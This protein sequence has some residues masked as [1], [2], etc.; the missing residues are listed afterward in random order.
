MYRAKGM[1]GSNGVRI[2]FRKK[3]LL[4]I[5]PM[6]CVASMVY[7]YD[8][9]RTEK[10]IVRSEIIKRAEAIT[11]LA[12][13]TGEL[14]ILSGSGEFLKNAVAPLSENPE[15]VS[16]AFF[17]AGMHELIR[18]GRP[19]PGPL[20]LLSAGNPISMTDAKDMFIFYAPIFAVRQ[21]DAIGI[22][23]E[24]SGA[25]PVREHIGW[26]QL[27]F[28]KG[29]MNDAVGKV[30]SRGILLA[31]VFT[32]GISLAVFFLIT[33]TTRPLMVLFQA[34]KKLEK[35]EY[36]EIKHISS[37][38]EIGQLAVAFNRMS[39]A[40]K[41]RESALVASENRLRELFERVEHAIFRLDARGAIIDANSRFRDLFGEAG[42][43]GDVV[44][45]EKEV[46]NC[47]QAAS[48][49]GAVHREKRANGK[50]GELVI[51]LS[52][53]PVIGQGGEIVGYDGYIMDI[54]EKKTMEEGLLRSQK[55]EAV[56]TLAG[57]MAHD[58]NNVLTAILGYSELM[59]EEIKE[60]EHFYRAVSTINSAAKRG[61][62]LSMKILSVTRKEKL[63]IRPID[64]N[65][66]VK[67]S[68]ELLHRSIPKDIQ[69]VTA[70]GP[71]IPMAMADPSQ[72]QQV[73]LNLAINARDAMSG[74]GRLTIGTELAQDYVR[75][76][77]SDTGTGMSGATR[78]RIFDP[79]F[80]T[81]EAGKGTGLG[82]YIVHS[83]VANHGGHIN[84]YSEQGSGTVFN[85]YVPVAR[86]EAPE[87][88]A[89][90]GELGGQET[91]LMI[92]DE[93]TVREMTRD[94]LSRLGYEVLLAGGGTE[95]LR[96]FREK[97]ADISL[98]ILDMVMPEM[99]G[100]DV[101]RLLKEINPAV[102][103]L[104][105]SGFSQEGFEGIENLLAQGADGFI[106]KPF[107]CHDIASAM[108]KALSGKRPV[109]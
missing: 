88:A 26:V 42:S 91:I 93:T 76:S 17:D 89:E 63:L 109:P 66:I 30:V 28:S 62:D 19:I 4:I 48:S 50:D 95:G 82:L 79:F 77:V 98:I 54:T 2:T 12:T 57:G 27:G 13:R 41:E 3:A 32:G 47:F 72:M 61:A 59:L 8:A 9:I 5:L 64:M 103:V 58:F 105:C 1:P 96:I 16:V 15:V 106:Q 43:F 51:S 6:L 37:T 14:P 33:V 21:S 40:I 25:S 44:G 75:L 104:I 100:K 65:E 108:R 53:Y 67:N 20:P 7:T 34:V 86:G 35:G 10:E 101:F 29:I 69:I 85:V 81:K 74:G 92:D 84:L 68:I 87:E 24:G 45:G 38:D 46:L 90:P 71:D 55:L 78:S 23:H 31:V 73:V 80:T 83:I 56:G 49:G 39:S 18:E 11:S 60:G 52:L 97:K 107:S 22:F 99:G 102:K 70:L 36:P 94:M